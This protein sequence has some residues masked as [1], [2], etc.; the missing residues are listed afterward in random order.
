LLRRRAVKPEKSELRDRKGILRISSSTKKIQ[1]REEQYPSRKKKV[2]IRVTFS[3]WGASSRKGEN[4]I[5][6]L[7]ERGPSFRKRIKLCV[8]DKGIRG[9]GSTGEKDLYFALYHEGD[10]MRPFSDE[11][12]EE[13]FFL[14]GKVPHP[15]EEKVTKRRSRPSG[16]RKLREGEER[17]LSEAVKGMHGGVRLDLQGGGK[18]ASCEDFLARKGGWQEEPVA[19][20]GE[21]ERKDPSF[22]VQKSAAAPP[23]RGSRL[24]GG[25]EPRIARERKGERLS[26]LSFQKAGGLFIL[27]TRGGGITPRGEGVNYPLRKR[28][29]GKSN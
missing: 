20:R 15:L 11:E 12:K 3:R 6:S 18:A 24:P 26:L 2:F 14:Q 13:G 27:R 9:I 23:G 28:E 29:E 19:Y 10:E 21:G 16:K 8:Y 17:P 5:L 1:G 7:Q 4:D 22:T 25:E